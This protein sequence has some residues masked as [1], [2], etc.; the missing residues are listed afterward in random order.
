[1]W[2]DPVA[3]SKRRPPATLATSAT[4]SGKLQESRKSHTPHGLEIANSVS[5]GAIDWRAYYDKRGGVAGFD[6][7]DCRAM[8]PSA[9][10]LNA[11]LP[12]VFARTS[13]QVS[14]G[15]VQSADVA[16]RSDCP[17]FLTVIKPIAIH[18]CIQNVGRNGMCN[19]S[20]RPSPQLPVLGSSRKPFHV[21]FIH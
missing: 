10:H 16:E 9:R 5:W 3:L 12:N 2:F 15:I 6:M 19:A 14:R 17:C 4:N 11:A 18:G 20:E 7:A 21:E 1:M 8:T 13:R